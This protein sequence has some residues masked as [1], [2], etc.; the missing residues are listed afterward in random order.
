MIISIRHK[1][2]NLK[3]YARRKNRVKLHV[4]MKKI[5]SIDRD[6]YKFKSVTGL[7]TSQIHKIFYK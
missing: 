5:R 6:L 2:R 4:L 1:I 3:K 7:T